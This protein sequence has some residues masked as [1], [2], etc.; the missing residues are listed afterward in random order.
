MT[1]EHKT[2]VDCLSNVY[3]SPDSKPLADAENADGVIAC[4]DA[5]LHAGCFKKGTGPRDY[6]VKMGHV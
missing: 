5:N 1:R 6:S 4:I 3:M 2:S